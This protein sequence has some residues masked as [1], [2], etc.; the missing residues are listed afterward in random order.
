MAMKKCKE[1]GEEI[2][3][4][5]KTCPKCGKKQGGISKIILILLVLVIIIAAASGSGNDG[6]VSKADGTGGTKVS[7]NGN[8]VVSVGEMYEGQGLKI[9]YLSMDE[10]FTEYQSFAS[11]S[12][13]KK[14]I[15]AEFEFENINK[16]DVYVS[17]FEFKCY[18]DGYDCESFI[19]VDDSGFSANLS[20]G[21]KIKGNVYFEVPQDA[22]EIHLE[23]ETDW[24]DNIKVE[25]KVK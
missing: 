1:C 21:K 22:Q 6:T 7:E 4:S 12:E 15:R 24:I 8:K 2:S 20:K 17:A 25:F 3:S 10:N 13:G 9:S 16:N 23:Y 11:V 5:A 18:A 14:I 19:W